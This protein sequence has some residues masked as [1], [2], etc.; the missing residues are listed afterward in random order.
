MIPAKLEKFIG[1]FSIGISYSF[2]ITSSLINKYYIY[3]VCILLLLTTCLLHNT[4]H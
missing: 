3:T 1:H 4:L 2:G